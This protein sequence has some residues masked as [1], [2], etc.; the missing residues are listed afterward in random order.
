[1]DTTKRKYRRP[2]RELVIKQTYFSMNNDNAV[3]WKYIDLGSSAVRRFQKV[4]N[5]LKMAK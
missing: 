4:N 1:M 2:E 3:T 5:C